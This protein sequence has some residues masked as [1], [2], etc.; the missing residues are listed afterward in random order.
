MVYTI[1][2]NKL[3]EVTKKLEK[4]QSK[5]AK[6]GKKFSFSIGEEYP[7]EIAIRDIDYVTQTIYTTNTCKVAAVDI[8][9]DCD[10]FICANG[11]KVVA[12]IEH[13]EGGNIVT[14]FGCEALKEWYT[15]PAHCD[16]CNTNRRRNNTFIVQHEN[17][18][19]KQVGKSCLEDY[20]GI[21]PAACALWAEVKDVCLDTSGEEFCSFES[22][23]SMRVYDTAT[24]IA[25][26]VDSI[27]KDGYVKADCP[28][29]TKAN[30]FE[31]SHK[32]AEISEKAKEKAEKIIKWLESLPL[33]TIGI[34]ADCKSLA[35]SGFCKPR[36]FGRLAY[37]PIA[38]Q[39]ATEKAAKETERNNQEVNSIYIGTIGEKITIKADIAQLVTSF[40]TMYGT[41]YLY[42][43]VSAGNVFVWFSSRPVENV[44]NGCA[45]KGTI[46]D[47]NTRDGIKQ[48]ILTRCKV[49]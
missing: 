48:T 22:V 4:L 27:V 39:K 40:P 37:I 41:T 42:K 12:H 21:S 45:I 7:A 43:F 3:E 23:A 47:H 15:I 6:Y 28:N 30:V 1:Y 9:I 35:K 11:W 10:S 25:Y 19:F 38:Y 32:N 8:S 49:V 34:E 13:G 16:H 14:A 29:S 46:K 26:A 33:D 18:E 44:V 5:A 24:I 20:T 17:G 31:M 2:A 36:H